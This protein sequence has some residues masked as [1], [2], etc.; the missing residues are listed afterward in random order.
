MG[1]KMLSPGDQVFLDGDHDP[2]RRRTIVAARREQD[3]NYYV[4]EDSTEI[5]ASRI[6]ANWCET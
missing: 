1:V 4:L 6:T 3:E 2:A 5:P